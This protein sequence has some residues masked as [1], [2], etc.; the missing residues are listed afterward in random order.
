LFVF[1]NSDVLVSSYI[2]YIILIPLEGVCFLMRGRKR[3]NLRWKG[4]GKELGGENIIRTYV[5][6]KSI[7]NKEKK[8]S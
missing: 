1:F 4:S 8:F 2:A 5:R 7:F 3:V 6:K